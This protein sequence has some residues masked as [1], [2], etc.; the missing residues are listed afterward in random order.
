MTK[1]LFAGASSAIAQATL[2]LCTYADIIG[3]TRHGEAL[4]GYST[5]HTVSEY[6]ESTL[7]VIDS[8]L[9]GLVYFPGTI[10]LKP[11][12]RLT[13]NDFA[14]DFRVNVL[15]AVETIRKYLPNLKESDSASIVLISTVA[16]AQGLNFHSSISTAK[17]AVEG[18]AL[19]LAAEFSPKIRV[20]VVAPSLTDTP[21]A[22]RLL[23]TPEKNEA[24]AKRHPLRR[25]GQASDVA[26]AV[27]FLLSPASSWMTG[28]VIRVDG[29]MST[30]IG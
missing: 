4:K 29:G 20:N 1:Y 30:V 13:S 9:D 16:T 6:A 12:A 2:K 10:N 5:Q 27:H 18:L 14:E 22:G 8:P 21:L 11:F 26:Q 7:P 24:S 28:Q 25:V 19:A 23:G 15:G 17:G 3:V